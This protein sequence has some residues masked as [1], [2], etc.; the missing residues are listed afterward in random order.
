[1]RRGDA[2]WET[3]VEAWRWKADARDPFRGLFKRAALRAAAS[4]RCHGTLSLCTAGSQR[5]SSWP[6][7]SRLLS[8]RYDG[9][10]IYIYLYIYIVHTV[11]IVSLLLSDLNLLDTIS[12]TTDHCSS[13]LTANRAPFFK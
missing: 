5:S 12:H 2:G 6:L 1:M 4:P 13:N 10:Y 11:G 3:D 7:P 9:V 8:L